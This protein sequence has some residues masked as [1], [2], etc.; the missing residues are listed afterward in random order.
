[1]PAGTYRLVFMSEEHIGE[2][3][4]RLDDIREGAETPGRTEDGQMLFCLKC[5]EE[6]FNGVGLIKA[7]TRSAG[8]KKA[9][10]PQPPSIKPTLMT[11]GLDVFA[12][13]LHTFIKPEIRYT[14]HEFYT[15][16]S[17]EYHAFTKW[18]NMCI[19]KTMW[20]IP[21]NRDFNL[22]VPR[23]AAEYDLVNFFGDDSLDMSEPR[24]SIV[25]G[26]WRK[27]VWMTLAPCN[28]RT[29]PEQ[30]LSKTVVVAGV[31]LP[32]HSLMS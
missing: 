10:H 13:T 24:P 23:K 14:W 20:E 8:F 17:F 27:W 3:E 29:R 6:L 26:I 2:L 32:T 16:N 4:H 21:S 19:R 28:I 22:Q 12:A 7:G 1:M 5:V 25:I 31:E 30:K 9:T 15:L 18:K 11:P